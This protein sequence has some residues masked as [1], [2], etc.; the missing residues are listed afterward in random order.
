MYSY[1]THVFG[2]MIW[3]SLLFQVN[4]CAHSLYAKEKEKREFCLEILWTT[5]LKFEAASG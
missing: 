3:F 5:R 1:P 2:C 4:L